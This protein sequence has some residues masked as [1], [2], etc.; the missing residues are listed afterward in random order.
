MRFENTCIFYDL[1]EGAS[2]VHSLRGFRTPRCVTVGLCELDVLLSPFR[3]PAQCITIIVLLCRQAGRPTGRQAGRQGGSRG[4]QSG[5]RS[6]LYCIG[7]GALKERGG[8]LLFRRHYASAR[9]AIHHPPRRQVLREPPLLRWYRMAS[10]SQVDRPRAP[11]WSPLSPTR[12]GTPPSHTHTHTHTPL[13]G[14]Q[15]ASPVRRPPGFQSPERGGR[16]TQ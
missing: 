12:S 11:S 15:P 13:T 1:Y 6:R 2:A 14:P 10:R 5:R 9:A 16:G 7:P 3:L 4:G 8:S